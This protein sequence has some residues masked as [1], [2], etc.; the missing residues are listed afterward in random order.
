MDVLLNICKS[1]PDTRVV[2]ISQLTTW[3]TDEEALKKWH[4]MTE[5]CGVRY[6]P[7]V[8]AETM[9]QVNKIVL[10]SCEKYGVEVI[11]PEMEISSKY[12]YDD[13]HFNPA[14]CVEFANNVFNG[15]WPI[16][17]APEASEF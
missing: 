17:S 8:L 2:F 10:K 5:I 12:F 7:E 15:I 1:M 4:W 11:K 16:V 9:D 13:C 6:A 14:G 3:G